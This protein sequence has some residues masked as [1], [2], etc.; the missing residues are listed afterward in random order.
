MKIEQEMQE[1][2][3]QK[4]KEQDLQFKVTTVPEARGKEQLHARY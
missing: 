2:L 1:T 3:K 4:I